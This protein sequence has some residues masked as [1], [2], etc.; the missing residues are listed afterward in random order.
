MLNQRPS[1]EQDQDVPSWS[2]SKAVYKPV[3]HIAA[4]SV[5]WI[6]SWW[7]TEELPETCRVS[8]RSKFWK[9]VHLVG[10][11]IKKIVSPTAQYNTFFFRTEALSA[12]PVLPLLFH[13]LIECTM[14]KLSSRAEQYR[15]VLYTTTIFTKRRYTYVC[16]YRVTQQ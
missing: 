11:I 14:W 1:F 5:Q 16:V 4:P 3:W 12:A 10:F 8:C 15:T 13:T 2:C 9:L 7:W 6:N